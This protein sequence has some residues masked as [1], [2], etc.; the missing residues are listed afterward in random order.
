MAEIIVKYKY[1]LVLSMYNIMSRNKKSR[2]PGVGSSGVVKT[3]KQQST[4]ITHK[5]PRKQTG[6]K[7]GNRQ[8]E[9]RVTTDK[10]NPKSVKADPRLGSKK[11]IALSPSPAKTTASIKQHSPVK[12][13]SPSPMDAL[14]PPQ[15]TVD[16][17]ATL[18]EEL[19]AIEDDNRLQSILTKQENNIELSEN[20]IDYYNQKM[21]RYQA[22]QTALGLSDEDD[23]A[24]EQPSAKNAAAADDDSLWDK[25]DNNHLSSFE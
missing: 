7:P 25:L 2:K 21:S 4:I 5:K 14:H 8:Q 16:S 13:P 22:L 24:V 15:Q 20:D 6:K 11:P 12:K 18:R 19:R 23:F 3:D 9:A 17:E 10:S 1:I